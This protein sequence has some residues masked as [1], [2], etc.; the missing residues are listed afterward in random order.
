MEKIYQR[1]LERLGG[2][3]K[4]MPRFYH[5]LNSVDNIV[6]IAD[7]E[8][9][10]LWTNASFSNIWGYSF[11][12]YREKH[13]NNILS[14]TPKKVKAM[15]EMNLEDNEATIFQ[16]PIENKYGDTIW[17][18]RNL[19]PFVEE[20]QITH[21]VAI[22]SDLT[23]MRLAMD[24]INSQKKIVTE[25]RNLAIAHKE[26]IERQK[27]EITDSIEYASNIQ[28]AILPPT[29]A[30]SQVLPDHF[31]L[32]KPRDIVSGDFYW[33]AERGGKVIVAAAD[34]TGHGVPGAFMS[35]LGTTY[36]NEITSTT[37]VLTAAEILN[38]LRDKV[39]KGLHQTGKDGEAKDGMDIALCIIDFNSMECEYAGAYNPF[40]MIRDGE[41]SQ[42]RADKMPIGIYIRPNRPFTNHSIPLRQGDV[43]YLFSDGYQDQF[44]GDDESKFKIK[45]M[46][47]LFVEIHLL[48][49]AEQRAIL[50]K[51]LLDWMGQVPQLDDILVVGIRV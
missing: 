22:D 11:S 25:Q 18:Q 5:A 3:E 33:I 10:I 14:Q 27:E 26:E 50:D 19:T 30:L 32:W 45:R 21:L 7:R 29:T 8:G 4:A 40:V 44:G 20:G 15:L 2:F 23:V 38:R 41:L 35:M 12:E 47:E 17:L 9:E 39:I 34:C 51:T 42:I 43:I 24:E 46:K 13:G 28:A 16:F 48:P 6:I 37:D 49:M 36:L 31:I 1:I